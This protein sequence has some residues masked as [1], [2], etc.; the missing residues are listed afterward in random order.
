MHCVRLKADLP[1]QNKLRTKKGEETFY[2]FSAASLAAFMTFSN[3]KAFDKSPDTLICPVMKAVAGDISLLKILR[4]LDTFILMTTS[5]LLS[6]SPLPTLPSPFLKS[7]KNLPSSEKKNEKSQLFILT[8][9]IKVLKEQRK[10][11]PFLLFLL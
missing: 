6:G 7:T 2:W 9:L 1:F 8:M 3:V 10:L 11:F 4:K 5:A